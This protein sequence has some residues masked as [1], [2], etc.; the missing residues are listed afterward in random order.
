VFQS[1]TVTA[2]VNT[3]KG[4]YSV[5]IEDTFPSSAV[6]G[7]RLPSPGHFLIAEDFNKAWQDLEKQIEPMRALINTRF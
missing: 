6:P 5:H 7:V 2:M 3:N 4:T 1:N